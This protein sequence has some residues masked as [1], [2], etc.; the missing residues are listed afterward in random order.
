MY[1]VKLKKNEEKRIVN[2]HPWIY[3]NEVELITGKDAQGSICKVISHNDEFIGIGYINHSSKII[4][5][6]LSRSEIEIDEEFFY[7]RLKSANDKRIELGYTDNYRLCFGESD[8]L[9]GLIVDRYGKKL[10][11]QILTLGMEVRK[12][13]IINALVRIFNGEEDSDFGIYERSDVDSRL[14]EGLKLRTGF[15]YR[16][17]DPLVIINENGLKIRVDIKNGQ[18]T[19]YFLD[20]KENRSNIKYYCKDKDV[21][22]CFCNVGGFSLNASFNGA[23][24]VTSLD[25]SKLAIDEVMEN[26]KLNNLNNIT[27]IVCDVF[28]KIREYKKDKKKFDV[29][30]LDPPAFIKSVDSIKNGYNGYL[31][32]NTLALKLLNKGGYLVTCSCSQHLTLPLFMKMIEESAVRSGRTCKLVELRFQ[33]KDHATLLNYQESLYL[34][35]AIINVV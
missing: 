15:L 11:V 12:Q 22:D 16:E 6:I 8:L 32:I 19:G 9:P 35:V 1:I 27:G 26:A 5:R 2:G 24:S 34:K 3:A 13:L 31:D 33:G 17:F 14:K 29:I 28:E 23:K 20:Q 10:V 21:L 25:I 18:K 4:V 7:E 30:V